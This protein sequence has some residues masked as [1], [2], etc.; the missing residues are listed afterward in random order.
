MIFRKKIFP[1]DARFET[2]AAL[3]WKRLRKNKLAMLGLLVILLSLGVALFAYILNPDPSTDANE[4]TPELALQQPG[5]RIQLLALQRNHHN[6]PGIFR[7]LAQGMPADQELVPVLSWTF[8]GHQLQAQ[9]FRGTHVKPLG[10]TFNIQEILGLDSATYKSTSLA[11]LQQQ[12]KDHHL[13]YRRYLL[14]TDYLGR[15]LFSRLLLGTRISLS[16]GC[17]AVIISLLLGI[18][19]GAL[20]GYF[21]GLTD[22]VVMWLVNVVWSIPTILF[23]FALSLALGK[24]FWQ[25]FLAV[26]LTMWVQVARLL[27]GQVMLLRRMEYVE[28]ARSMGFTHFRI[29]LRHILPNLLGPVMVVAASNF[30]SAILV[31]AGLSFIGIGVQPP[32]PSWGTMI[33]ENYGFLMGHNAMLALAPGLAIMLLVLA[34]NLV[35]NGLR[36]ALDVKMGNG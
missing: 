21:G 17:I 27:R 5:F 30:A 33:K 1:A 2:P 15:D 22:K 29:L 3:A 12:V 8:S 20:A 10:R 13:F 19:L 35:G 9:V 25:I 4:Q 24:G 31:E 36:D 23:V 7:Q 18:L 34:F 28:A 26:G 14:G 32:T 11:D 16:V 6:P